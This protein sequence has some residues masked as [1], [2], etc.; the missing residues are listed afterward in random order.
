MLFLSLTSFF[1]TVLNALNISPM[2]LKSVVLNKLQT[3]SH[4]M[5]DILA[6]K[7]IIVYEM[8]FTH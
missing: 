3:L 6:G 5:T 1:Y 8:K 7:L 2:V 4:T